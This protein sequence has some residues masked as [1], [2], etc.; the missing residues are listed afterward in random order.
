MNVFNSHRG[1][2]SALFKI[3]KRLLGKD[4]KLSASFPI[5]CRFTVF[6]QQPFFFCL[7]PSPRFLF[8]IF[9]IPLVPLWCR[10][11]NLINHKE[12]FEVILNTILQTSSPSHLFAKLK[13]NLHKKIHHHW[14]TAPILSSNHFLRPKY[15]GSKLNLRAPDLAST[16]YYPYSYAHSNVLMHTQPQPHTDECIL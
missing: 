1:N 16:N 3:K 13:N 2:I 14:L 5:H 6:S 11:A 15:C 7:L 8:E 12:V 4:L 9:Q 10:C